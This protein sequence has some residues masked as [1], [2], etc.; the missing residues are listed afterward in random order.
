MK[1]HSLPTKVVL[2]VFALTFFLVGCDEVVSDAPLAE[3]KDQNFIPEL[4]GKW[5]SAEKGETGPG[6]PSGGKGYLE[7]KRKGEKYTLVSSNKKESLEILLTTTAIGGKS[8]LDMAVVDKGVTK[9]QFLQIE[10]LPTSFQWVLK[11][12]LMNVA[13]VL[14]AVK[15]KKLKGTIK[16]SMGFMGVENK[17][18]TITDSTAKI[19]TFIA[20]T[21][22]SK[23]FKNGAC[24]FEK[25]K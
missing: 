3:S 11:A 8:L 19:R 23:L 2:V 7:I 25:V 24:V 14:E 12:R 4:V 22:P 17:S 10:L 20:M 21:P 6:C 16:S 15:K 1:T 5:K 9:H 13:P 18:V